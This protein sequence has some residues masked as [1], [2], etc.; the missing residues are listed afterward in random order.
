MPLINCEVN[1]ILLC[2]E[3]CVLT[4]LITRDA[5]GDNPAIAAPTNATFKI[6]DT[7]LH[8][9]VVTLS[10]QDDNKLLKQSKTGFKR[11]IK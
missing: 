5:E 2:Y 7:K 11:T 3:N 9:P 1:L 10:T 4:D 6:P 8:A